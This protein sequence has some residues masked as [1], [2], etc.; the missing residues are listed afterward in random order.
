LLVGYGV[1]GTS[2]YWKIQNVWGSSWGENGYIR[3]IRES[4]NSTAQCGL[5]LMASYPTY[6]QSIV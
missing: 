6:V 4:G 1:D 2:S 3:I 5:N